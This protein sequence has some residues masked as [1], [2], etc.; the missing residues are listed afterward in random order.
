MDKAD[1][2]ILEQLL[3]DGRLSARKIS[4]RVDMSTVTILSRVKKMTKANIIKGYTVLLDAENMGY[5]LSVIIEIVAKKDKILNVANSFAQ[6]KNVCVVYTHTGSTDITIIAKFRD[7]NDL[8]AFM[9]SL[10]KL[11]HVVSTMSNVILHTIKEDFRL[12]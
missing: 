5:N 8:S 2:V 3:Y 6:M 12:L 10:V 9:A 7:R 4:Q 1:K 11:E